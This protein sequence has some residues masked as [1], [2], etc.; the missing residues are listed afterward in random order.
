MRI[1]GTF[2]FVGG[3]ILIVAAMCMDTTIEVGDVLTDGV[4]RVHNLELAARQD[5]F[6][7][8][9]CTAALAGVVLLGLAELKT[10]TSPKWPTSQSFDNA[11]PKLPTGKF[12]GDAAPKVPKGS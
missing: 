3:F 6:V 7:M 9:G 2:L 8:I 1:A 11:E 10:P 4:R 12:L 5:H